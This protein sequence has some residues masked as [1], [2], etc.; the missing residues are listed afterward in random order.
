M[1]EKRA[2]KRADELEI[3]LNRGGYTLK[4]SHF[5]IMTLQNHLQMMVVV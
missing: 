5:Q 4:E 1:S 2:M 3:V